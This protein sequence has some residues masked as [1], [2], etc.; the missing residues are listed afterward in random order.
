MVVAVRVGALSLTSVPLYVAWRTVTPRL[1]CLLVTLVSGALADRMDRRRLLAGA[2]AFRALV[3]GL[4]GTA[5]AAGAVTMPLLYAAFFVLGS[6]ETLVDTTSVAL[7][8]DVVDP[9]DLERANG[10]LLGTQVVAN[11]FAAPPLGGLLFATGAALPFL[12][13]AGALTAAAALLLGLPATQPASPPRP[14]AGLLREV[15]EGVRFL[16]SSPLLRILAVTLAAMNVTLFATEAVLV[17][18]ARERLGLQGAGY[19]ALLAAA[20]GGGVA[21]GLLAGRI[22]S[23]LGPGTVLRIGLLVETATHVVLATTRSAVVAGAVWAV[24]GLHG[25]VWGAVTMSVRQRAIPAELRGR[26]ASAAMLLS[27]GAAPIGALLGGILARTLGLTAPAWFAAAGMTA[28][29]PLA[30]P[31]L[32]DATIRGAEPPGHRDGSPSEPRHP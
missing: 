30:W 20:G 22:V 27:N 14:R 10:R 5:V 2:N 13:Q 23:R 15:V 28:L 17:L 1:P 8:P 19:G 18:L 16:F 7:L 25:V 4:L 24:F 32:N 9:D 6:A 21:G 26:V 31:L 12:A 3:V 29:L 11:Q